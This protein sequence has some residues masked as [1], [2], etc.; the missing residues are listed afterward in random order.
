MTKEAKTELFLVE[1]LK[2]YKTRAKKVN[3]S[4]VD[5]FLALDKAAE[6]KEKLKEFYDE[7]P[8]YQV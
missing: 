6:Y 3:I 4:L 1:H 7:F 2:L 5:K 8:E